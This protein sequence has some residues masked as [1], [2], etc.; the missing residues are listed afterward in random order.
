MV[1]NIASTNTFSKEIKK[2]KKNKELLDALENKIKRLKE[3]PENVGGYLSG[4]LHGLKATRII[5][6]F[7]LVFKINNQENTV[8]LAGIDHRKYD[9]ENFDNESLE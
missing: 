2:F 3:N 9:Y 7:R 6:K 1:W 8:Y 4:R 5:K